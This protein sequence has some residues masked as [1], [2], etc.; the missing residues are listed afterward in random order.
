MRFLN[1]QL[2]LLLVHLDEALLAV[3]L[4]VLH[5][6]LLE[7]LGHVG[8]VQL[9]Q[10]L[11]VVPDEHVLLLLSHLLSA[12]TLTEAVL[13]LLNAAAQGVLLTGAGLQLLLAPHEVIIVLLLLLLH[14]VHL[15]DQCLLLQIDR[16]DPAVHVG[17]IELLEALEDLALKLLLV[18][19]GVADQLGSE[20][21]LCDAVLF[22]E[23]LLE[24]ILLVQLLAQTRL[25]L[26]VNAL[27]LQGRLLD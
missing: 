25:F 18:V 17:E 14:A 8:A 11:L 12:L 24:H 19:T 22:V 27:Q 7:A 15:V 4:L 23:D 21:G 20:P 3:V 13:A 2:L 9:A 16:A 5:D 10:L 26:G 6:K 1:G